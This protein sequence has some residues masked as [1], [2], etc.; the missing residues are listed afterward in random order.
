MDKLYYCV[1]CKRVIQNT[2]KCNFCNEENIK[3]LNYGAPV[4]IIGS[5]I[6]GKVLKIKGNVVRL[7]VRDEMNIKSIKE[8][9]F[10][11]L[12]KVL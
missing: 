4:N 9:E 10:E 3:E 7:I 1:H 11:K 8:Y 2:D 6:K 12:R 5:K